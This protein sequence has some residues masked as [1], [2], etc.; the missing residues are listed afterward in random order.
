MK[1]GAGKATGPPSPKQAKRR[2]LAREK[3]S[4]LFVVGGSAGSIEALSTILS[5][6]PSDFPAPIL[7]VIHR[8]TGPS[9][10]PALFTRAGR[11]KATHATDGELI[12]PG[13][14]Y[15]A[16]P[17]YH[18]LVVGE[19]MRLHRGPR[20]NHQRPAVDP[21]FRTAARFYGPRVVGVILSG[22]LDCGTYGLL[23]VKRHGGTSVVQDPA[24]ALVSSMPL[25]AVQH[26]PIDF[27][28]P[29]ADLAA[30]L[31]G[32]ARTSV[33]MTTKP[34]EPELDVET[35]A[36]PTHQERRRLTAY[37]CPDCSGP[38]YEVE[39]GTV[40]HFRCRTGHAFS[41]EG[42]LDGKENAI[43]TAL[44]VALNA[45]DEK[46]LLCQRL[47]KRARE[48]RHATTAERW[49]E[50]AREN[51]Q[52]AA[53]IRELLVGAAPPVP[54][55]AKPAEPLASEIESGIPD[56]VPEVVP[57]QAAVRERRKVRRS[58]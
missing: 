52:M 1:R 28:L 17:D 51:E 23:S 15:L 10:L 27:T 24:D 33:A 19:R 55:P 36:D 21:L 42:L 4:R 2:P 50:Q 35:A 57:P 22:A 34:A 46:V 43:E 40:L 41:I 25:S 3:F 47:G 56:E 37:V 6:L 58:R 14:I 11:L 7:I 54:L 39:G 9:V 49:E 20:E 31:D 48:N 29:A 16:P 26:V 32:L 18:L 8:S 12:R 5:A 45:L 53:V 13:H 44:W 38:L 30:L